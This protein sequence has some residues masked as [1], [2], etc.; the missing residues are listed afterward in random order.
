[1]EYAL[2]VMVR[3]GDAH[4]KNFGLLYDDPSKTDSIRLSPLFDVVTTATYDHENQRTGRMLTDRTLALKLNKSKTYP[5]RQEMLD[6]GTRHCGV[7]HPEQ[8]IERIA[9]SMS[10][11][12][13]EYRDLFPKEFAQRLSAEWE[14]GQSS[15]E[16]DKVF[17]PTVE[18]EPP[19]G[20]SQ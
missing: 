17:M 8:V 1:M 20:P 18:E 16:A 12:L 9:Q 19:K 15:L 13:K 5:V 7:Q 4:L 11:T 14:A 6:F 3:N 2:S 10:E